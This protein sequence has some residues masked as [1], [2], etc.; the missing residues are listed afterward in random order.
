MRKVV[1]IIMVGV[2][3]SSCAVTEK[4]QRTLKYSFQA[5]INKGGITENTNLTVLSNPPD[6][7]LVD[8]YSGATQLGVNAG[9]HVNKPLKYGEIE[10]GLDYMFNVQTFSFAHQ[11]NMYVGVRELNVS[12]L[13]IPFTYN[14][15]VLR[16]VCPTAE[17]QLKL[18]LTGQLN[19]VSI[20]STGTLPDYSIN[21][22][23]GGGLFG[24]SAY[25]VKFENGQKLGFYIDVYRGSQVYEDYY[26]QKTFETPGSSF[27]KGGI[28]YR[29]K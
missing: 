4:S 7:N 24:I 9:V 28:R 2:V 16:K 5:G 19:F 13:M 25:P 18:G 22:L 23:S 6:E 3:L 26:N 1:L 20:S 11:E 27:V 15:S 10:S 17:L 12:Q 21:S 8:A 14:F 29:F